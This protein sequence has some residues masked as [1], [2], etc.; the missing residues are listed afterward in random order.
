M[1]EDISNQIRLLSE[2]I[3]E[4]RGLIGAQDKPGFTN[5]DMMQM[6]DVASRT[7][8]RWRDD[9]RIAYSKVGDKFFYSKKDVEEFMRRNHVDSFFYD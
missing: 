2:K 1:K 9:G 7:L 8:K 4:I 5:K 3:D 6:F